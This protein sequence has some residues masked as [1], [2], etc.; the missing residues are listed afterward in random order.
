MSDDEDH[1]TR[2]AEV[3]AKATA[4][5]ALQGAE[6]GN[7]GTLAQVTFLKG[8]GIAGPDAARMLGVSPAAVRMAQSRA[9]KGGSRGKSKR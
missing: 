6:V 9:R 5:L 2:W 4:M 1:G 3:L 8:L 7:E